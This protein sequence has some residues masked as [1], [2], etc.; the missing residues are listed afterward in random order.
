MQFQYAQI[1]Q[2]FLRLTQRES[3]KELILPPDLAVMRPA[4]LCCR[5]LA[6]KVERARGQGGEE[7][8]SDEED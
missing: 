5:C 6:A 1:V 7:D 4:S 2:V 8:I 3:K